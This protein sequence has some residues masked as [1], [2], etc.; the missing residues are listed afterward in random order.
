MIDLEAQGPWRL[1][2]TLFCIDAPRGAMTV[3]A[4]VPCRVKQERSLK[5][6]LKPR[7]AALGSGSAAA[8][9][10]PQ[11]LQVI[12]RWTSRQALACQASQN[13]SH[14]TSQQPRLTLGQARSLLLTATLH[15]SSPSRNLEKH[16]VP[17]EYLG[18]VGCRHSPARIGSGSGHSRFPMIKRDR[19]NVL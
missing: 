9:A 18:P 11:R 1:R 4:L 2:V 12:E 6:Y 5:M 17:V 7:R 14:L 15:A 13:R 16:G 10:T 8:A 3:R 19:S